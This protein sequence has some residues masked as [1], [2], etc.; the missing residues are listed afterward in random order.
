MELQT[1]S[2]SLAHVRGAGPRKA[3][4]HPAERSHCAV[5]T[6]LVT[7]RLTYLTECEAVAET[8][9]DPVRTWL[10]ACHS[11]P[12]GPCSANVL[13][14]TLSITSRTAKKHTSQLDK[15]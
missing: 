8:N 14:T 4:L 7:L 2:R 9:E 10:F 13:L 1:G 5:A 6:G 12:V 11:R 15:M 3:T